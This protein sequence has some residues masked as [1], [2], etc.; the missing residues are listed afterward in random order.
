MSKLTKAAILAAVKSAVGASLASKGLGVR[1]DLPGWDEYVLRARKCYPSRVQ[2]YPTTA[3]VVTHARTRATV[4]DTTASYLGDLATRMAVNAREFD[5][6]AG[7]TASDCI[8]CS[9]AAYSVG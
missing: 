8:P 6:W 5:G 4:W 2:T 3:V 9:H 1:V 7:P